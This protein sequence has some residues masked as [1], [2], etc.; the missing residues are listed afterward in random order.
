MYNLYMNEDLP[1]KNA[2]YIKQ[3]NDNVLIL[4]QNIRAASITIREV[5]RDLSAM[6]RAIIELLK[7]KKI[8]NGDEDMRLLQK[9]HMRHVAQIDQEMAEERK[10]KS[11]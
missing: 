2:E 8:I 4:D 3:L 1:S 10:K 5:A 11:N 6:Q 7:H 9:F